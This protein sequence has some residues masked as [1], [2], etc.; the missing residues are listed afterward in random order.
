[1]LVGRQDA[2]GPAS[3]RWDD[4]PLAGSPSFLLTTESGSQEREQ[5]SHD[6][7]KP[8]A[9]NHHT[10]T[11][12]TFYSSRRMVGMGRERRHFLMEGTAKHHCKRDV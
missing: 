3:L 11:C 5:M 9:Q 8:K 7:L 4:S 12:P 2:A 1:M 6:P 10:I